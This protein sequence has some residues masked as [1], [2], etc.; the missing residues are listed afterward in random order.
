MTLDVLSL[1]LGIGLVALTAA[2]S[3]VLLADERDEASGYGSWA[4]GLGLQGSAMLAFGTR[5]FVPS[6]LADLIAIGCYLA[7]LAFLITSAAR[8]R[9]SEGHPRVV[10]VLL[11]LPL[12]GSAWY[13]LV[14]PLPEMRTLLVGAGALLG[15]VLLA[16]ETGRLGREER[17]PAT[18]LLH[19]VT[20]TVLVVMIL[21]AI[22][23]VTGDAWRQAASTPANLALFATGAVFFVGSAPFVMQE[24][25]GVGPKGYGVYFILVSLTYMLA[26]LLCGPITRRMGGERA[27]RA[28]A[29]FAVAGV[30]F[31][32][33]LALAGVR[34]P[35]VLMSSVMLQ[36]LGAGV[37]VPN[38]MAG[39]VG[40]AHDRPGSASGLMGFCQFLGGGVMVQLA[41]FLPHGSV[42]PTLAVMLAL[43]VAGLLS[44]LWLVR[45]TPVSRPV[46][47]AVA[48]ARED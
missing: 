45:T 37:S 42:L 16:L 7:S 18:V 40:A 1:A 31:G 22:E 34:D 29:L 4:A 15:F 19:A 30:V 24:A 8:L 12:L 23:A 3:L 33:S 39:A 43:L 25:Y 17:R 28:G 47:G 14:D 44:H 35:M 11:A 38:A 10:G 32:I 21:R 41:G 27:I 9:G 36:S 13:A 2:A 26:N 6:S 46:A 20:L 48:G 5:T